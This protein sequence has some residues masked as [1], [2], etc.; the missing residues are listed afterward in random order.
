VVDVINR[1]NS[2]IVRKVSVGKVRRI[3][4]NGNK[5]VKVEGISGGRLLLF[6]R[7]PNVGQELH[8]LPVILKR[9]EKSLFMI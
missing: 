5:C 9:Q 6:V 3:G 4:R 1:I 8:V 2:E 7:Q